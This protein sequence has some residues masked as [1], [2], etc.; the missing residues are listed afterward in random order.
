ML[1]LVASI[2]GTRPLGEEEAWGLGFRV[3]KGLEIC[4]QVKAGLPTAGAQDAAFA[5]LVSLLIVVAGFMPPVSMSVQCKPEI[6][7]GLQ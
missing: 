6:S 1:L 5:D 7:E 3:Y 2:L 4:H